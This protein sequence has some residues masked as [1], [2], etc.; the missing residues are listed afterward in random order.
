MESDDRSAFAAA[1]RAGEPAALDR[2]YRDYAR[3][4]LGWCVRLG[5]PGND[6]EDA[7]QEVFIVA[8]RQARTWRGDASLTTWL[9]QITRRVLANQRRRLAV[10]RF[11]GLEQAPEPS[12]P[13]RAE[14]AFNQ[15]DARLLVQRALDRLPEAQREALVLVDLDERPATEAAELLGVPVGTVYSR[16]HAAR[17]AFATAAAQEGLSHTEEWIAISGGA[18]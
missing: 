16:L 10:R 17:R 5:A 9:F 1:L 14:V 12:V 8:L 11:F 18:T 4:V 6:A 3:A 13:A 15:A 7:A 2:L